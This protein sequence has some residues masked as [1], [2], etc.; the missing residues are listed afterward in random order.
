MTQALAAAKTPKD[1]IEALDKWKTT[2][3][4]SDYA[5][6]REDQYLFVYQAAKMNRQAFDKAVE[7]LKN[8]PNHFHSLYTILSMVQGLMPPT[9]ADLDTTAKTAM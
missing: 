2:F 6:E 7:I 8:R 4:K 9:P 5:D 1:Q 3:P